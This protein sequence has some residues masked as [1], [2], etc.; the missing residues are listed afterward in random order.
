MK[1][2][3]PNF[4]QILTDDQGW[5][6]LASF[7]HP[8]IQSP[9]LD[10]LAGEG[11]KFTHCYAADS[12]CSPARAAILTGRTPYR[13]GV[14]RWF[15]P[16]HFLHL[17]TDEV[18][19]PQLLR[20]NGYQT[21]HFGKWH[22]SHFTEPRKDDGDF[23]YEKF[24][25]GH[26]DH[27]GMDDYGYDYSFVSANVARPSHKDPE[28][29][30][31]NGK[32]MGKMEGY[33]AQIVV[34][35][36]VQWMHEHRDRDEPFFITFWLHEPHGPIESDPRFI[37]QYEGIQDP[38]L[39]QYMANVTQLDAAVGT[40]V[41]TLKEAGLYDDTLLW[42][43]SDNGP[44]GP[45]EYGTFNTS[46]DVGRSRFRGST[47][48]LRGRK[49]HTHDG[50]IRVPGIISWPNGFKE[51]GVRPGALCG[52]PIIGSDIFPTLLELAG[53]PPPENV[54][55]DSS[56]LVPLFRKEPFK[57]ERPLYWRNYIYDLRIALRDAEYKIIG[58]SK[59]TEFSLYNLHLDP[60][61][62]ADLSAHEPEHF[63]A[64]KRALI[65]YD[66]E[67]IAEGPDWW[68]REEEQR[69]AM[70]TDEPPDRKET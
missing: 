69:V 63:D 10:R 28:N 60:R 64:M 54:T 11:I 35:Q 31:L 62:T 27:P 44:E 17:P 67:V 42:Y 49:R 61:E 58:N 24:T 68:K 34:D 47:G 3:K 33:S 4:I 16:N 53:V 2:K 41:E 32:L 57:R 7:G 6:D 40:I 56:S 12:V 65:D 1:T 5:G 55:L 23:D 25:F 46:D 43:T 50:G 30:F 9:H 19:L 21:A 26:P 15:P 66:R 52:E 38:S 14:Y 29:F 8:F 36:F 18:T 20:E 59:R 45:H 48:G 51:F 13:N 70:P 37:E 22:L 39:C